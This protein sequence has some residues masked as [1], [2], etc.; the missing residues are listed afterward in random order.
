MYPTPTSKGGQENHMAITSKGAVQQKV[1]TIPKKTQVT[2]NSADDQE[3]IARRTRYSTDTENLQS[4]QAIKNPNEPI[5]NR[6]RS[7]TVTKKHTTPSHSISLEAQ[8][9]TYVTHSLS[10]QETG[11]QLNYGQLKKHPRF[12]ETRNK[13]FS[14]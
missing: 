10:D 13:S 8:L 11:K 2:I 3:A 12:Q 5:T 4:I 7:H 9:I 6:T 14:N 1:L